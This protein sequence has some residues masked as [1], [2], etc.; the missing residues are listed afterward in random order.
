MCQEIVQLKP[1][2]TKLKPM[3]KF[4]SETWTLGRENDVE[5]LESQQIKLIRHLWVPQG[6]S[7]YSEKVMRAVGRK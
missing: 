3:F 4:G 7:T 6:W 2:E 5:R 1:H